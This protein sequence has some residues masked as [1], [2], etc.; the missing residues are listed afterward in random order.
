MFGLKKIICLLLIVIVCILGFVLCTGA[1]SSKIKL[2]DKD[3]MTQAEPQS[4]DIF[5]SDM[6]IGEMRRLAVSG[7]LELYL[8]EKAM[9]V[10]VYDAMADMLYRALP[11]E[12]AGEK[13]AVINLYMLIEG[14]EYVLSSQSDSLAFGCTEYEKTKNGVIIT[15]NFRQS[16]KGGKKLDVSVPVKFVLS[17]GMLSVSADCSRI[18]N[19]SKGKVEIIALEMLPFF[20]S[21]TSA[22]SGDYILLP[23]GCGTLLRLNDNSALSDE[24]SLR[25]YGEDPSVPRGEAADV[26][27]GAFGRKMGNGAFVCLVGDGDALC[28]VKADK[29]QESSGYNRVGAYFEITPVLKE[30]NSVLVS[31]KSYDGNLELSYRFLSGENAVYTGMASAVRELL[32]RNGDLRES[33]S[34]EKKGYPFNLTLVMSDIVQNEKGVPVR[35]LLSTFS[36]SEELLTS[37]RSKGFDSINVRLKGIY[38]NG[39]EKMDSFCGSEEASERLTALENIRIYSDTGLYNSGSFAAKSIDGKT[40]DISSVGAIERKLSGY[41]SSLREQPF[42]GVCINDAGKK[43]YSDYSTGR[44]TLRDKVRNSLADILASVSASKGLMIETGN[45]YSIKYATDIINIPG[46]SSVS[47]NE[48]FRDVPFIQT[49][50]HGITDYSLSAANLSADSTYT[51]LKSAEYGAL[52]HYEWSCSSSEVNT[53]TDKYYYWNS[54]GEAKA[55]YDKMKSDFENIGERRITEH[56]M[57]KEDVYLTCFGEDMK[58]YVNYSDESVNISGITVYAKSYTV[59]G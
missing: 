42:Y 29:A 57:I 39:S 51:M 19:E 27:I 55:Y 5:V 14:R 40:I 25:V 12:Y 21:D 8:D 23:D 7:M 2:S 54:L 3:V 28:S 22:S 33:T 56:K 36:D 43:L 52:P 37:L 18:I 31:S 17:D 32:I 44:V 48:N 10:C 15:Y 4:R 35:R 1:D 38:K 11:S 16:L 45:L 30:E 58:V 20:G 59:V 24:I 50:L 49:I 41:I 47:E 13:T 9:S 53:E 6:N 26:L 46:S 34:V